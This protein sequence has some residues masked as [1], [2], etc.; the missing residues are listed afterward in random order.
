[1]STVI[2]SSAT[3]AVSPTQVIASPR[4]AQQTNGGGF[5]QHLEAAQRSASS[6]PRREPAAADEQRDRADDSL[7]HSPAKRST[8]STNAKPTA[9]ASASAASTTASKPGSKACR[10]AG[11]LGNADDPAATADTATPFDP[12]LGASLL[13]LIGAASMGT[14][15]AST[16]AAADVPL[17]GAADAGAAS[18][19]AAASS[20]A[21][22]PA[23]AS[24]ASGVLG[25][26]LLP[27]DPSL[28]SP[29][30]GLT[31][32]V[33]NGGMPTMAAATM[34]LR[35]AS[36]KD[37]LA[38]LTQRVA[39][40]TPSATAAPMTVHALQLTE[41][42]SGQ[43]FQ[44]ALGQQVVW[45]TG[46]EIKQ[47]SIRLHPQDLG[48]LDIKVSV[49]HG[50]VNV[51]INA[52]HPAAADAVQQTLPQL[53]S[54]LAQHGLSLGHADVGHRPSGHAQGRENHRGG[55]HADSSAADDA[56]AAVA[57]ASTIGAIN[58]L[59]AFA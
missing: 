9:P 48:Q 36:D 12:T 6:T 3:P 43:A 51:V 53:A 54:M 41:P 52:Q 21:G 45:L 57:P 20:A 32:L 4:E 30:A 34:P 11:S 7:A 25:D 23:S 38:D 50:S 37:T 13:A 15:A 19:N 8:P 2:S 18:G 35:G 5:D 40:F 17:S 27:T 22:S 39:L 56:T 58:L 16:P 24:I 14:T 26:S 1:M 42:V 10:A 44:Q 46:Q 33:A 47:A 49:N 29:E 31:T 55:A 28:T 59:D